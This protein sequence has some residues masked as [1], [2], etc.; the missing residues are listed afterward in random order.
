MIKIKELW[1]CCNLQYYTRSSIHHEDDTDRIIIQL[2]DN[3]IEV[4]K[5]SAVMVECI[6]LNEWVPIGQGQG[7]WD[8]CQPGSNR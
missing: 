1:S 6:S 2:V 5:V 8:L 7:S 3:Y 4:A